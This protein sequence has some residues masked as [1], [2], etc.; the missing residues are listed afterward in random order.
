MSLD[1]N[2]IK[3][4]NF[5]SDQYLMETFT[6]VQIFIHHTAGGPSAINTANGWQGDSSRVATP[7]IIAGTVNSQN[8]TDGD[9]IQCFDEKYW[10]YHLGLKTEA[11]TNLGLPYKQLDKISIAI[12]ICN[13]G[14]LTK[15]ADGTFLNYLDKSVPA[16]EVTTLSQPYKGYTYFH[17]YTDAQ[18]ASLKDLLI[19]LTQKFGINKTFNSDIFDITP[20]AFQGANG[21]YTHNSVRT[22]KWDIYPCPRMIAMLS[23]L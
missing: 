1:I 17:R 6:K 9:I 15:Q 5:S 2:K 13:W 3:Q 16:S 10:A 14:Q 22:D 21:I 18:I 12:E 8:E 23:S 11:F 20:R 7:Y 4:L 19:Y